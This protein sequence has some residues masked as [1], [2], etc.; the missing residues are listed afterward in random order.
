VRIP[1]E[2]FS[3]EQ[4]RAHARKLLAQAHLG[5]DPQGDK[6][7]AR[8]KLARTLHSVVDG[9]LAAK[10]P[11]L[12]PGSLRI[13]RLYLSGKAYFGPLHSTAVNEITRA[14]VAARLSAV[15][16]TS[17]N[18][19]AARARSALNS[20]FA[21]AIGEGMLDTNPVIGTNR[22]AEPP[23][24]DRVLD[25]AE[26]A[27]IW[28]AAGEDEYG[29][30]IRLLILTAARR[31]EVA[32][33]RWSELDL[34]TG[35]WSLPKERAK[36]KRSLLLPLPPLALEIINAIEVRMS[37][38]ELFGERALVG[39]TQWTPGKT[40]LDKR[41]SGN[42]KPWRLHDLR[43]TTATRLG[44]LGTQPHIIEA[45]LNH[46]SG[47]R[48]GV[49]GTYNRSPYEREIRDALA[50]WAGHVQRLADAI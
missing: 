47:F 43:R 1:A 12:R 11:N 36:N 29:K 39:F 4:A 48:A 23:P 44:D 42:V 6:A 25:D 34:T 40:A 38:D 24:R 15:A 31:A 13:V 5:Q 14:D 18:V 8:L 28:A 19:T 3:A 2:L 16:R 21:W 46:Y 45:L 32:G 9:Y 26:L 27:A 41:L 50:M 7:A 10:E 33:L 22:P 17:G 20:M 49:S 35:T 37:R 30:I